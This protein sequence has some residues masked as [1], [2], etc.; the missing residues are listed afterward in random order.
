MIGGA[1]ARRRPGRADAADAAARPRAAARG[2]RRARG[3][4]PHQRQPPAPARGGTPARGRP[5]RLPRPRRATPAARSR[6]AATAR[7]HVRR[8]RRRAAARAARRR[9]AGAS[10]GASTASTS[11]PAA[12]RRSSTTTRARARRRLRRWLADGKL[13]MG[14]YM[15]AARE[16]LGLDVVG[17]L[18]QPLGGDEHRPRG[19]IEDGADP[20]LRVVSNDRLASEDVRGAA[21]RRARRARCSVVAEIRAGRLEPRPQT[22]GWR[23]SRLLVSVDLPL[24]GD[25]TELSLTP[26]Q[27]DAVARRRG[28]AAR[29]RQRR[30]GQDDGARRALRALRARRRLSRPTRSSRSRSP[31]R[32]PGRCA[33]A[34]ARGCSRC[35][36]R[37]LAQDTES[38]WISTIHGSVHAD[39]AHARRRGRAR[40]ALRRPRRGR[41]ARAARRRVRRR[42][43][44][45]AR[46]RP[47]RGA[48]PRRRLHARQPARDG[49][50]RVRP[51]AQRGRDAAAAAAA[52]RATPTSTR[53][54]PRCATR[55]SPPQAEIALAP[56]D[57][58][59]STTRVAALDAC[60]QLRGANVT[61]ALSGA[62]C[63]RYREAWQAYTQAD[64]DVRGRRRA[65][66]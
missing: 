52:R 35:G 43:G 53:S 13:Q 51:A 37:R 63:A 41:D 18:Y 40:P 66:R 59:R 27:A 21:G 20:G 14:L 17:G 48:R 64:I 11:R 10:R 62:A 39:P 55:R 26:E 54:R 23:D 4:A 29:R 32:R 33:R 50:R 34:C 6:R 65:A 7:G 46:R 57:R 61:Q 12:T 28:R 2:A 3:R 30:L 15:L 24:R 56:R 22:C 58:S 1:G 8:P 49:P 31:T 16:L 60:A 5:R 45:A 42:A 47:R 19:A 38:A 36:Q 44:R 9:R 25:V